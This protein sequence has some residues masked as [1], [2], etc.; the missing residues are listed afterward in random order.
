MKIPTFFRAG[1][2]IILLAATF[3]TALQPPRPVSAVELNGVTYETLGSGKDNNLALGDGGEAYMA[4]CI[5]QTTTPAAPAGVGFAYR[6]DVDFNPETN[7]WHQETLFSFPAGETCNYTQL[8]FKKAGTERTLHLV[9]ITGTSTS[10]KITYGRKLVSAATWNFQELHSG[11]AN[12]FRSPSLAIGADNQPR[13]SFYDATNKD[14]MY[15]QKTG[16]V[17]SLHTVDGVNSVGA[18][19]SL[20]IDSAGRS[21]IIYSDYTTYPNFKH[22]WQDGSDW[23][24]ES[25]ET[26]SGTF[27]GGGNFSLEI[28]P[29]D[30]LHVAYSH[31]SYTGLTLSR[32]GVRYATKAVGGEWSEEELTYYSGSTSILSNLHL[33]MAPNQQPGIV[34]AYNV[35]TTSANTIIPVWIKG[36]T[37]GVSLLQADYFPTAFIFDQKG[38]YHFSNFSGKWGIY[39]MKYG[40]RKMVYPVSGTVTNRAG[41]G[42]AGVSISNSAGGNPVNTDVTGGFTINLEAGAQTLTARKEG[43]GFVKASQRI[44]NG[45]TFSGTVQFITSDYGPNP[46]PFLHPPV[47]SYSGQPVEAFLQDTDSK[48]RINSWFDHRYPVGGNDP[49]LSLNVLY[50]IEDPRIAYKYRNHDGIDLIPDSVLSAQKQPEKIFPAADGVVVKIDSEPHGFGNFVVLKHEV[51]SNPTLVYYTLYGHLASI[52]PLMQPTFPVDRENPDHF[53]GILGNTG[54]SSGAHLHFGVYRDGGDGVYTPG[55]EKPVDPFGWLRKNIPDPNV[56]DLGGAPSVELFI[57]L[58]PAQA[59]MEGGYGGSLQDEAFCRVDLKPGFFSGLVQFNLQRIAGPAPAQGLR[60]LGITYWLD[61]LT[62][63]QNPAGLPGKGEGDQPLEVVLSYDPAALAHLD[64]SQLTILQWDEVSLVW[65]PLPSTLDTVE[66]TVT[67]HPGTHGIFDLQAPLLC[68]GDELEI[69]DHSF[70]AT[71]IT[72]QEDITL[73]VLDA[74]Q[75]EDWYG[76]ELL[77]GQGIHLEVTDLAGGVQPMLEVLD[78]EGDVAASGSTSLAWNAPLDGLYFLRVSP[79]EGSATGC[80]AVYSLHFIQPLKVYIPLLMR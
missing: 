75:D 70:T 57:E 59:Q 4:Y 51:G 63:F 16:E 1:L 13:L 20:E 40:F 30:S 21:H 26:D 47:N 49:K 55:N 44:S 74:P 72:T 41:Q 14:L 80:L 60:G 25:F 58:E 24:F 33:D 35:G 45:A 69:N 39:E 68:P 38:N 23:S 78:A 31:A 43:L 77:A 64:E 34:Y 19:S 12:Q 28:L 6:K 73:Q 46:P 37:W 53:I 10:S 54:K 9:F 52:N 61:L 71:P 7:N 66:H 22:A 67:A 15:A 56:Q 18:S 50:S 2:S 32:V 8:Q 5:P 76:F 42:I 17:W 36:V 65:N 62:G 27:N 48:G 29:G 79:A 3:L 11:T